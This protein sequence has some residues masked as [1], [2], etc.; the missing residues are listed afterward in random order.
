MKKFLFLIL[1]LAVSVSAIAGINT[2]PVTKFQVSNRATKHVTHKA[3]MDAPAPAAIMKVIQKEQQVVGNLDVR[4]GEK[5]KLRTGNIITEQPQGTVVMYKR[6]SGQ[7]LHR[8]YDSSA[9]S[10][11][12]SL[13]LTQHDGTED[14][15]AVENGS[16]IYFKNLLYDPDGYFD[17][18]WIEGTKSSNGN[19]VTIN[20][21][22][23]LLNYSDGSSIILVMGTL[24]Y[25]SGFSWEESSAATAVFTVSN[26]VLTL[27]NSA[28]DGNY[29]GTCL[30][31]D[32][33]DGYGWAGFADFATVLT[34]GEEL[35]IEIPDYYTDDDVIAMAQQ[36]GELYAYGRTGDAIVPEGEGLYLDEQAGVTYVYFAA[37]GETV[38]LRD[39]AYDFEAGFWAKGTLSGN[40]ITVPLNQ[41]VY[42]DD[43][44]YGMRL[45]WGEFKNG[46]G[47]YTAMPE[48]TECTY[49]ITESEKN[50]VLNGTQE[51]VQGDTADCYIGLSLTLEQNLI[52]KG[53]YG[54]L[55]WNT[56][57]WNAPDMPANVTADPTATTAKINWDGGDA[58]EW[59]LR[60]RQYNPDADN[61]Y[62]NDFESDV[63]GWMVYDADGD[64]YNWGQ[65]TAEYSSN[66]SNCMTSASWI[67]SAGALTPDN[68]LISPVVNLNGVARFYAWGQDKSYPSEVFAVYVTTN[69][70]DSITTDDFELLSNGDITALAWDSINSGADNL[71]IFDLSAYEG[72]QGRI[73]I[74]H[75]NVTDMFYLDVDDFYVGDPDA[76]VY[77]WIEVEGITEIPYIIE[78]LTPETTYEVQVAGVNGGAIGVWTESTIFTTLGEQTGLRG[79][80]DDNG[81]VNIQDVTC[82][83]NHLLTQQW[84]DVPGQ[85]SLDNADCDLNGTP[86]IQD[87]TCLINY[88]LSHVWPE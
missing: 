4:A 71:Q 44:N 61:F 72:Q 7:S 48:V 24:T 83:I 15:T 10:P 67:S 43:E 41:Y 64:N 23:E 35:E 45:T 55:N 19:R 88:L 8:Y 25:N 38:Y 39:P 70:S 59:N 51:Y 57:Y 75:Y 68:W 31:A 60:Y 6:T 81:V 58:E 46:A 66:G 54:I 2:K 49:T 73:A 50:F 20:L 28:Y 18:Y 11:W 80:V 65:R 82:L 52:E 32:W 12:G 30:A 40:T 5:T 3:K 53:W 84:D 86:N 13:A 78:G 62:F 69:T 77:P 87:V 22:Q 26:G 1:S 74:R 37:D 47:G 27:Q 56:I 42:W 33:D 16:K 17:D 14:I 34:R 9:S 21:K 29:G 76:P 63:A 79:D 85:F 36:G